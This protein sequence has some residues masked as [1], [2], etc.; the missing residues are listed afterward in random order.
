MKRLVSHEAMLDNL[1]LDFLMKE[2]REAH[3]L[4]VNIKTSVNDAMAQATSTAA[5]VGSVSATLTQ[6]LNPGAGIRLNSMNHA[7]N[8]GYQNIGVLQYILTGLCNVLGTLEQKMHYMSQNDTAQS[9][10]DS[11]TIA[12]RD[13]FYVQL[14]TLAEKLDVVRQLTEGGGFNT[15]VGVFK[16]LTDVTVLVRADIP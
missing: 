7:M 9:I 12:P 5:K 6:L 14:L 4:N 10:K 16:S 2:A 15:V 11:S 3:L 1:D 13:E 8:M